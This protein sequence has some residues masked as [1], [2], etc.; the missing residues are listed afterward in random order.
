VKDY[1]SLSNRFQPPRAAR[2]PG[3]PGA[4]SSHGYQFRPD[5]VRNTEKVFNRRV[6]SWVRRSLVRTLGYL[7]GTA[8]FL[9]GVSNAIGILSLR[10]SQFSLVNNLL[11]VFTGCFL[12]FLANHEQ[13]VERADPLDRDTP[14]ARSVGA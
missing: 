12:V 4:A 6:Q 14:P 7:V 10:G 2:P 1:S 8:L 3:G 9:I 13:A 11:L 5:S